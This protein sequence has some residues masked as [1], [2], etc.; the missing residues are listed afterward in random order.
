MKRVTEGQNAIALILVIGDIILPL[1]V[2]IVS[3]QGKGLKSKPDIYR[4][5]L[6]A[7][8]SRF[9]AAGMDFGAFKTTG[10]AAYLKG[11]IAEYCRGDSAL[12]PETI[13][14][15]ETEQS[16]TIIGIFGGKD[17]YVFTIDGKRQQARQ[18]RKDL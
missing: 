1:A 16:P 5:M 8:K 11:E 12:A 9:E 2:R 7:A 4:E 18:W 13:E 17:S 15:A 3:K 6:A 10:D 14:T